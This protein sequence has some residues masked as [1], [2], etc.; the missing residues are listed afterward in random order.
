MTE[1]KRHETIDTWGCYL[2]FLKVFRFVVLSFWPSLRS[3]KK[4][5]KTSNTVFLGLKIET[6]ADHNNEL[7]SAWFYNKNPDWPLQ[8]TWFLIYL[9]V[10]QLNKPYGLKL[11]KLKKTPKKS[12]FQSSHSVFFV[13][14]SLFYL[15]CLVTQFIIKKRNAKN[16]EKIWKKYLESQNFEKSHSAFLAPLLLIY[17]FCEMI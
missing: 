13:P 3:S 6:L 11:K 7:E 9:F 2:C 17:L 10:D 12:K 15:F 16:E 5:Q 4:T 1:R 14:F 8:W